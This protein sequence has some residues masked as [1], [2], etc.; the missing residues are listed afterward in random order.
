MRQPIVL[1]FVLLLGPF[2]QAHAQLDETTLW[3]RLAGQQQ[4]SGHFVQEMY[5]EE[6]ELIERS[7][8]HYAVLRP[9]FFR[10]NIEL[11]DRQQI[12][13]NGSDLWHYDVDLATA[14]RRSTT[15]QAEFTPLELLAG[16]TDELRSRF[17]VEALQND[18]YR[19]IPVFAQ[20]GFASVELF[21]EKS[22][23][24]E[25]DIRDRSGQL[26][27]V[28]LTPDLEAA[29]LAPQDFE[30]SLPDGVDIYDASRP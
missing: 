25:M 18:R 12:V 7:S 19:L 4:A 6:G 21:W 3:S 11:P 14:T 28:A 20:A 1:F 17:R 24:V 22:E 30:L 8:G 29:V 13:V 26:I 5:S 10:W 9:G 27:S 16:A 23:I 15:G 2:A